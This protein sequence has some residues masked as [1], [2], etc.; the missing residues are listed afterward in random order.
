MPLQTPY[1]LFQGSG[2]DA[3][4]GG[5]NK[6][7]ITPGSLGSVPQAA[8]LSSSKPAH[9]MGRSP[10][11]GAAPCLG[12]GSISTAVISH[13]LWSG[14]ASS[15]FPVLGNLPGEPGRTSPLSARL[16]GSLPLAAPDLPSRQRDAAVHPLD[17]ALQ[18]PL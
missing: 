13:A 6:C 10:G 15:A 14:F 1:V 4:H 7:N 3:M 8:P 5:W 9:P 17:P 16:L 11:A 18:N 12:K 2:E